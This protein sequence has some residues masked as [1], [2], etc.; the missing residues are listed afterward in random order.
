MEAQVQIWT[1][2]DKPLKETDWL[3]NGFKDLADYVSRLRDQHDGHVKNGACFICDKFANNPLVSFG[4][5]DPSLG[6]EIKLVCET[7]NDL[8]KTNIENVLIFNQIE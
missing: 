2:P 3:A 6:K 8:P 7:L 5:I 4:Y 1:L